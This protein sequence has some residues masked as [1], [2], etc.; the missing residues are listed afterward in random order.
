MNIPRPPVS[1]AALLQEAAT[2]ST[3][4]TNAATTGGV[5]ATDNSAKKSTRAGKTVVVKNAIIYNPDTGAVQVNQTIKLSGGNI[6]E[7]K[8]S[9]ESSPHDMAVH[10]VDR[11]V[12]YPG[13]TL[14]VVRTLLR[15]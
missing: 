3:S 7:I 11:L 9:D 1:A 4:S 6:V 5:A 12:Y 2:T 15:F 13:F 8:D 10:V 14:F